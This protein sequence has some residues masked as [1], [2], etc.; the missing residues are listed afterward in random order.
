V[1]LP[2]FAIKRSAIVIA[3]TVL[4]SVWGIAAFISAPRREDPE[5]K[6]RV[7]VILT[8]WPG[9][10][11]EKIEQ[12]ITDPIEKAVDGL[13]EVDKVS[14]VNR[15]GLS[16]VFVNVDEGI[17]DVDAVWDKVRAK[18][19]TVAPGL[20]EGAG[21]PWVDTEYGDTSAMVIAVYQ[22]PM[23]GK[24]RIERPYTPRELELIAERVKDELKMMPAVSRADLLG[25][26]QEAIYVE[27]D[28]GTWSRLSLT[29]DQLRQLLVERNIVAPGGVIDTQTGSFG[30]KPTGELL[31]V[32]QLNKVVVGTSENQAPTYLK[33]LGIRISRGYEDPP[34]FITRY[35]TAE[36][37]TPCI[38][39]SFTM[40]KGENI[41][42]LG[43]DARQKIEELQD[44]ILPRDIGIGIVGDQ[45]SSVDTCIKDFVSN[46]WQAIVIVVLVAYLL[47]GFRIAVVMA[48]AIPVVILVSF[49]IVRFFGVQLE[50]VSIASL[51]IA[52]GMLVDNAI[53]VG[54]NIHRLLEE[55]HSRIDA[56]VKGSEEIA[57]PVLI[58]TLTTVAAFLPMLT[59]P[60]SEGEYMFSLPVVVSTTLLVSWFLAMTTTT[61]SAYWFLRGTGK[62]S[63]SP[64][65]VLVGAIGKLRRGPAAAGDTEGAFIKTTYAGLL[66]RC[67]RHKFITLA[68]SVLAFAG[69]CSLLPLI[70]SQFFPPAERSQF[71][72]DVWLP[73]GA[74][75]ARTDATC[76][77]VEELIR[78]LSG[79]QGPEGRTDRLVNMV[80]YVGQ[81]GPRF[82]LNLNPE[83]ECNNYA[84][85]VVNTTDPQ[86]TLSLA[87]DL[88][89]AAE[90]RVGG[91]RIVTRL[92][93][94]G[95]GLDSPIGVRIIGEDLEGLRHYAEKLKESLR[96]V[97]GT[98]DVH[99]TWGS[100][101][102]ELAV[103]VDQD[104]ANLA[105]VTNAAVAQTLQAF[106]SGYHLTTYR[107]GDHQ[108]P[109]YLRLPSEQR[110][111]LDALK[112]VYVEGRSGKV[113]LDAVA[114]VEPM[115]QPAKIGRW[116][117]HRMIEVRARVQEGL[118]ANTVLLSAMP[119][120][121][122]LEA[123]LP[124][125]YRLE[126]GG[127]QEE[128]VKSQKNM[129]RAFGI[130]VLLIVMCL[131]IQYNSFTKPLIIL[132]TL[133]MAATGSFLGLFVTG[134]PLGFMAML[135]LLSLAGIVLNDA[136]VLIEFIEKLVKEKLEKKSGLAAPD[137]RS[138]GGLA[139][140][141]FRDC[142]VRAGQ[143]RML[144][145]ML[146]TLT[147]VG[148]LIP[149]ALFGG[150]LWAPMAWVII[151]GLMLATL[152]TLVVI[153]TVY[154]VFVENLG[155]A[156]VDHS[157]EGA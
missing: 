24:D 87:Q 96:R 138:C 154:S 155:T 148:G 139:S 129:S 41:V 42:T 5:F 28:V 120:I 80:S 8:Q 40:K 34:R 141:A 126:I 104:R 121:R 27:T 65:A 23:P 21:T 88:R 112:S 127:E 123:A 60:G 101:G 131:V 107:E 109:V 157:D 98:I 6:I 103:D 56:A 2:R 118:L 20:P 106:F 151:F 37:S 81:G 124:P 9:A 113:P 58:A 93:D 130:S 78:E 156:V 68:I 77:K 46:L 136:I 52:L 144:P 90:E 51:I 67:L 119:A 116:K 10:A 72:V 1:S 134:Y 18:V 63:A 135:G 53:E 16:T 25:V 83:Q 43:R 147:T 137:Q 89:R 115:W 30:L 82:Y 57:F 149:L 91:A 150:P 39:V 26:Q 4:A 36:G 117:L 11:A 50:Q 85:I 38:I 95:P 12:L 31:S 111:S 62:H 13:D 48:S 55:G 45:P 100:H 145:I 128:T 108:V 74:T 94:M 143:M 29:T 102:Y 22:K 47:I 54:D 15:V 35:G 146:T 19:D 125:G 79:V 114:T 132:L 49:G 73:E 69:A 32:A 17:D 44:S 76:R 153:P 64:L 70:G 92:L 122:E 66:E 86:A 133:P 84:Q 71:T 110:K 105:G 75:M 61:L 3:A 7:C 14:S 152:L 33:D 99:D 97:P 142:L 140:E 59:L